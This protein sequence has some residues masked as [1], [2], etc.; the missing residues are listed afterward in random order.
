MAAAAAATAVGHRADGFSKK[1]SLLSSSVFISSPVSPSSDKYATASI[2]IVKG[3]QRAS[4]S[5]RVAFIA[6]RFFYSVALGTPLR[7]AINFL[8]FKFAS[9]RHFRR[10]AGETKTN[11]ISG[12]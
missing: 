12:G 10:T 11:V 3:A 4:H 2:F 1:P 7:T 9:I 6:S 8:P 5:A